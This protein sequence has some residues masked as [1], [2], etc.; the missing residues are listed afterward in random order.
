MPGVPGQASAISRRRAV[1]GGGAFALTA[2]FSIPSA[3][4]ADDGLLERLRRQQFVRVGIANAPPF[5]ALRPDGTM[6]GVG[7]TMA[8]R[9]LERL[10]IPRMEGAIASY[11]E[12]IPGMFA[13]RWDFVAAAMT[14]TKERCGQ[15]L[16]ADP[17]TFEGPCIV[18][19]IAANTGNPRTIADLARLKATV[20]ALSGGAQFRQLVEGGVA[21]DKISQFA[22]ETTMVDGLL[23]GRVQ[24]L[25]LTHLLIT[26]ISKRRRMTFDVVFPV[27]DAPAPGASNVFRP[28]DVDF[29]AA[30]QRELRALKAT[31][32][33]LEISRQSGFEIPDGLVASTS[34]E[35]CRLAR[36]SSSPPK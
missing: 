4:A 25:Y 26:E 11:G 17:M 9:V 20:G 12:L 22:N 28:G 32:E 33:Y 8:R 14:I 15:V 27:D 7:P 35:Q 10:G 29:H 24:F 1:A 6:T 34:D 16:Y 5:S 18:A 36:E 2:P 21:L 30:Y 3:R 19:A 31:G 23:A 13:G